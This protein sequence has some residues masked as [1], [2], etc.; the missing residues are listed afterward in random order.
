MTA[1]PA[2][3]EQERAVGGGGTPPGSRGDTLSGLMGCGSG[4]LAGRCDGA[5]VARTMTCM[6]RES[7]AH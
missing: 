4:A 2:C 5:C 3:V 1:Q 6:V 7:G